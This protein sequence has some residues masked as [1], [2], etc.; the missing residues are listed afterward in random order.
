MKKLSII[1]AIVLTSCGIQHVAK[2]QAV[3]MTKAITSNNYE[4][5]LK[6][7][8]VNV[9]NM[10]GSEQNFI[11]M[12]ETGT[13]EMKQ[14]GNQYES[15]EIGRPSKIVKAGNEIHCMIP[16][17]IHM[18]LKEGRMLVKSHLLAVSKD[19]GKNWTF[20][21]TDLLTKENITTILP[22]YNK[23]LIIPKKEEPIII[24]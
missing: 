14:L 24:K 10:F 15:I 11:K 17:S 22:N 3:V 1:L 13:T 19:K 9:V 8:H 23:E 12:L 20:V 16:E 2:K 6:Y 5:I 21:E 7:T 4:I 18:Q